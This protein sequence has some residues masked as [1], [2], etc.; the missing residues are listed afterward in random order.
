MRAGVLAFV[1]TAQPVAAEPVD[2]VDSADPK[3]KPKPNVQVTVPDLVDEMRARSPTRPGTVGGGVGIT[4]EWSSGIVVDP[5]PHR[6]AEPFG[7][8]GMVIAPPDVGDQMALELGTNQLR[9]HDQRL[10]WWPRDLSRQLGRGMQK[11]WELVL[12]K[13]L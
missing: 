5:G 8:G 4:G 2:P 6:D 10:P 3:P 12:P 7:E 11:F 1:L 9:S 13:Q